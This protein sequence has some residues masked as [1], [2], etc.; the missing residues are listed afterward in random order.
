MQSANALTCVRS[1]PALSYMSS[2]ASYL[3][4]QSLKFDADVFAT[5][6][7]AVVSAL[8][9][10]TAEADTLESKRRITDSLNTVIERAEARV[11]AEFLS[12]LLC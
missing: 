11:S 5:F 3:L 7:P 1:D 9:R 10:L 4:F 6:L 8:V 2:C 12:L